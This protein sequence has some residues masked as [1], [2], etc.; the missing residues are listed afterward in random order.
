[1]FEFGTGELVTVT[2]AVISAVV[3]L[4]RL[5]GRATANREGVVDARVKAELANRELAQFREHVASQYVPVQALDRLAHEIK[6]DM[7]II[8]TMLFELLKGKR[9]LDEGP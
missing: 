4:V 6:A 2:I 3:W 1:M 9:G 5:E 7:V 8:R